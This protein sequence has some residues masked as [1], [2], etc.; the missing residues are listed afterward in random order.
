MIEVKSDGTMS[1]KKISRRQLLKSS[2]MYRVTLHFLYLFSSLGLPLCHKDN[3]KL[4]TVE[5]GFILWTNYSYLHKF[6]SNSYP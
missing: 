2:G 3:Q 6:F 4:V 1:T 5:N